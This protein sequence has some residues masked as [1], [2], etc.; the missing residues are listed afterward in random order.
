MS[1]ADDL[2][3]AAQRLDDCP[4]VMLNG[5]AH[6]ALVALAKAADE[7]QQRADLWGLE[8]EVTELWAR[9]TRQLEAVPSVEAL[10]PAAANAAVMLYTA[11]WFLTAPNPTAGDLQAILE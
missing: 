9:A 7:G 10:Y 6:S 2:R 5:G 4:S 3:Q 1:S 11:S 8:A